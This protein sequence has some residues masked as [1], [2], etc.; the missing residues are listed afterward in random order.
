MKTKVRLL[1]VVLMTWMMAGCASIGPGSV[2][3]DRFDYIGSISESWKHQILLNIVKMRY[4][5]PFSFVDVGQIVAGYTLET[6]I[7]LGGQGTFSNFSTSASINSSLS[8]KY[9]DRPTITYTPMTGNAFIKT[10]MT[11]LHPS[12]LLFAIQ[13]GVQADLIFKLG[14]TSINGLRNEQISTVDYMPAEKSFLR[15]VELMKELQKA[16][17]VSVKIIR[18]K[19]GQEKSFM[20][21]LTR[22]GEAIQSEQIKELCE[23]LGLDQSTRQYSV[24]FGTVAENNREIA[25]QT[26]SVLRIMTFLAARVDVPEQ[27]VVEKRA[28]PGLR[29]AVILPAQGNRFTIKSSSWESEPKDA[30]AVVK[31][32]N[33]WFWIDDRDIM[34]KRVLSFLVLIFT[35]ADTGIDK[36]PPM[37]TIPTY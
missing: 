27:D 8:G 3:R 30:F 7:N 36:P 23:L 37:I 14:V 21:F 32:R 2:S 12:Q 22:A 9:T 28:T 18:H 31:Y 1:L 35:L 5:E 24:V 6:G 11:P 10:M 34:S 20:S 15:V 26:A 17:A 19:D 29:E 33:Q 16:G 13:S 4:L 25:M